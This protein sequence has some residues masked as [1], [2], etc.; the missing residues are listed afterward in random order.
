MTSQL[1]M[2]PLKT[3][4]VAGL[5]ALAMSVVLLLSSASP[6]HALYKQFCWGVTLPNHNA[7]CNGIYN[8][9]IVAYLTEVDASG[10]QHAVCVRAQQ[11]GDTECSPG[12]NQ[13]VY[14]F[15]PDG[16][17]YGNWGWV[18]NLGY[19]PNTVYGAYD[20]CNNPC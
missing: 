5:T 19:S 6:A 1:R 10:A 4:I 9:G 11:T 17:V 14:N 20:Y 7:T 2:T 13:G 16:Q 3:T 12:P 8:G 18:E 15:S